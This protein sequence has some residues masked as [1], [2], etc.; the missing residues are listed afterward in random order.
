MVSKSDVKYF[1]SASGSGF[2]RIIGG[3]EIISATPNNLFDDITPTELAAGRT[4]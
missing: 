4:E 1:K 3:T 2:G